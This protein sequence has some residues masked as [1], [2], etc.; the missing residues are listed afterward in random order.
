MNKTSHAFEIIQKALQRNKRLT[1]RG[2]CKI[3]GVSR[4]GYYAWCKAA[5]KRKE[6]EEQ[7]RRDF[8]LILEAYLKQGYSKGAESIKM[9]L[10][11]QNP[12]IRMNL[13]KIRRLMRKYGL[14]CPIRKKN[15]SR[16]LA[17]AIRTNNTAPNILRREFEFYGPRVVLL[18]DITYLSYAGKFAYLSTII[19][20]YTKQILAHVLSPNLEVDFVL[21]T[22]E[23]LIEKHG[24]T[25]HPETILHSDQGCH[26]TSV[27][28]IH[29][30][31][32]KK[33]RRSM[34]RKGNCWDNAPQ[35]SFF[36]H[37]KD[38]IRDKLKQA[39]TFEDVQQIVD[40]YIRYYNNERYQ[41]KLAKLSPNEFYEFVTTG[42]YP[43]K[44]P[45]PPTLPAIQK[46]PE[47]L[48]KK[49]RMEK[50]PSL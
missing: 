30:L 12:S 25:L 16:Q 29:L 28:Y 23:Q 18:T 5:D 19:D 24:D 21:K 3:V 31:N 10:E 49:A 47:E 4:S 6:R 50:H 2:M 41:W 40:N 1:V 14:I 37:M 43:L 42:V 11:H 46:K 20:A 34:S 9:I 26:Y 8:S 38:H 36:G 44:T 17:K 48:G 7:D 22:V 32:E 33:L 45:H 15:P 35:E 13:K 39:K 27:R